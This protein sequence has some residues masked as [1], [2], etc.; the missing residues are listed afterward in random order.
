MQH[1]QTSTTVQSD[2][3]SLQPL[4]ADDIV[5]IRSYLARVYPAAARRFREPELTDDATV[6]DLFRSA[7]WWY[8]NVEEAKRLVE[9]AVAPVADLV[10]APA[11]ACRPS[12]HAK[13]AHRWPAV[14]DYPFLPCVPGADCFARQANFDSPWRS[15]RW[16]EV[17]HFAF[18]S[19]REPRN[20]KAVTW[21]DVL[22]GDSRSPWWFWHAPGSGIFYGAGAVCAAPNK[23]SMVV[24]LLQRWFS[25]LPHDRNHGGGNHGGGSGGGGDGDG[26]GGGGSDGSGGRVKSYLAWLMTRMKVKT[27]DELIC[28]FNRTRHGQQTCTA[29]G[30]P[31]CVSNWFLMDRWDRLLAEL[32]RALGCDTLFFTASTWGLKQAVPYGEL[33]DLRVADTAAAG[34][35]REE[36]V[37]TSVRRVGRHLSLR[38]PLAPA[39]HAVVRTCNLTSGR[40]TIRLACPGHVSWDV[41]DEPRRERSCKRLDGGRGSHDSD[42]I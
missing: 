13:L 23:I 9:R 31:D 16:F 6:V 28:R 42:F 33:V 20:P 39:R 38:D 11:F 29:S 30:I 32:G 4:S 15:H 12:L 27:H 14:S 21:D 7:H 34:T 1:G 35:R 24:E 25:R 10:R 40:P 17:W 26:D 18:K 5:G 19:K 8:S 22:D 36:R 37:A 2:P 3:R 41:R